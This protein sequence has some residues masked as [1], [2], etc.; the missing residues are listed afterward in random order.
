VQLQRTKDQYDY[1]LMRFE[2]IGDWP[3]FCIPPFKNRCFEH[4]CFASKPSEAK[5]TSY[6]FVR[7]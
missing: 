4:C 3:L 5:R 2:E 1:G 6:V 7:K